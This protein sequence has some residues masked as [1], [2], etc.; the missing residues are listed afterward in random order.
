[1][2]G[3]ATQAKLR[4]LLSSG[5][6]YAATAP[7]TSAQ[8]MLQHHTEIAGA[9]SLKRSDD[10]GQSCKAC[11]TISIPGWTSQISRIDK[12]APKMAKRKP[13]PR[14][15]VTGQL[16]AR[17]EI[18]IRVKCLVC[19]RFEDTPLQKTKTSRDKD[20]EKATLQATF[21][22]D[23]M[24]NPD[25]NSSP[26]EKSTKASRRRERARNHKSGLQAMLDKS[27]APATTSLGLGLDLMD[28]MKEG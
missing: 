5:H 26:L 13:G 6:L 18:C 17:S 3:S 20:R 16:P 28:L 4:F 21:P 2:A 24:S 22:L 19:H 15:H 11:G 10:P 25:P 12:R 7:A 27:R 9:P 23:A 14:K 8:L 1:M